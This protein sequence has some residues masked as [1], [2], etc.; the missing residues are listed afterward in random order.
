MAFTTFP[1]IVEHSRMITPSVL[2]L[3]FRRADGKDLGYVAGQFLNIHFETE[4]KPTH[5]SYSIANAPRAGGTLDIAIAPVEGGRATALL[6]GLEPG[7]ELQ[8]SGPFG[9]FVLR[10]DPPCRYVWVGTGTGV[11]PYRAMLPGFAD[12]LQE[13]GYSAVMLMGVQYRKDK[14][15]AADFEAFAKRHAGFR[16]QACLSREAE[17]DPGLNETKGYVQQQFEALA[18]NPEKDIVYLCGNPDMIDDAVEILKGKGFE[19][20]N[21][22]REKYLPARS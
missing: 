4:G 15:Y 7:D 19:L 11:T 6:F 3:G 2:E 14:L 17:P 9:R 10:D 13:V 16:F 8:A 20:K 22:R 18:L 1:L 21:L 12:R 5:R